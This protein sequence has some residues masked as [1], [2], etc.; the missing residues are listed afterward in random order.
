[1]HE[2][3]TKCMTL[4][5][6]GAEFLGSNGLFCFIRCKFDSFKNPFAMITILSELYFRSRRFIL[7]IQMKTVISMN[8]GDEQGLT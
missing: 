3:H 6:T 1:M 2:N 7:L 4:D 5:R 8:H